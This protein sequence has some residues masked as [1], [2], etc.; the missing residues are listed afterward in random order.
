MG[1]FCMCYAFELCF[2]LTTVAFLAAFARFVGRRGFPSK[3]MSDYEKNFVGAHRSPDF[4]VLTPDNFLRGAPLL[5][6]PEGHS[7]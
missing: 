3:I 4:T 1:V 5:T 6:I 7:H 2:D